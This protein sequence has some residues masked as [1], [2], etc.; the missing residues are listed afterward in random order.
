[1]DSSRRNAIWITA[2]LLAAAC[3]VV[4]YCIA[5]LQPTVSDIKRMNANAQVELLSWKVGQYAMDHGKLP[6][7]LSELAE[8][9]DGK[10]PYAQAK[11]LIDPYGRAF[12]YVVPGAHGAFDIVFLGKDGAPG[13]VGYDA[14]YGN[15][16]LSGTR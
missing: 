8:S 15:W 7:A 9:S 10:G 3:L 16:E 2:L 4:L 12:V 6:T 11:D 5:R 14:D 13:G 1:M